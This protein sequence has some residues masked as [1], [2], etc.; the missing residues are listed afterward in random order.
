M[1][2]AWTADLHLGF[3]KPSSQDPS[4]GLSSWLAQLARQPFDALLISG[5]ISEAPQLHEHLALLEA[6]V[7]RPVYFVLGNHD[8]YHSSFAGVLPAVRD[9]VACSTHLQCLELLDFVELTP[10]TAIVGHGCWGDGLYGN[11]LR[12]NIVLNDWKVIEELRRWRRGP[13]SLACFAGCGACESE[14]LQRMGTA[15]DVDRTSLAAE[16]KRLGERAANHI[17][18]VLPPALDAK[19]HVVLL[20]HTPP[21]APQY[22]YT[23]V[24]WDCWAPHAGCKAVGDAVRE[25][26][27]DYPDRQLLILSGHVHA[28]S[29]VQIA[30]NIE[31]RTAFARYGRPQVQDIIELPPSG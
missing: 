5:D 25:I 19:R 16:L 13:W 29:C 14:A 3:V 30:H 22:V 17:R 9:F 18:R 4:S 8:F 31:Q 15:E 7:Q 6:F 2:V 26:L 12:S 27:A 23:R 24:D 21:F 11:V 1:R 20:T 28:A 10:T